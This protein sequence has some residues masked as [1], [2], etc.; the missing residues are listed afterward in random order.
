MPLDQTNAETLRR[1][2]LLIRAARLCADG[3]SRDR[4]L[5]RLLAAEDSPQPGTA[6]ERLLA[7]EEDMDS[8]R[9]RAQS[10]YSPIRHVE[11]LSAVIAEIRLDRATHPDGDPDQEKASGILALRCAT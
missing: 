8:Q 4:H 6:L 9:R 2:S 7:L 11:L 10:G 3:Y 5:N 1:P